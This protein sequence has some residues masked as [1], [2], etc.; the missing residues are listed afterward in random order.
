M[1]LL[2]AI[3][4]SAVGWLS[5]RVAALAMLVANSMTRPIGRLTAAAEGIGHSDQTTIPVDAGS[6]TGVLARAFARVMGDADA[7]TAGG[8]IEITDLEGLRA[9]C[10]ECY[11]A[12]KA[13]RDRLLKVPDG[14]SGNDGGS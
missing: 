10:C 11:Q 5:Y 13:R 8:H 3:A 1:M 2:V 14:I 9:T 7:K 4:V 12:V 6:E